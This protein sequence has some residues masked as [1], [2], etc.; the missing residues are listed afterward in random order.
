MS[1][2]PLAAGAHHR[3]RWRL[4]WSAACSSGDDDTSTG[5]GADEIADPGDCTP[6]DM[7]VSSEKIALLTD[8]ANE[9]NDSTPP[10]SARACQQVKASGAAMQL[11]DGWPEP[12]ERTATRRGRPPRR[13]DPRPAPDRE[14][15]PHGA[16]EP[17]CSRRS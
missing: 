4:R 17:F 8:L 9:F 10:I 12:G 13:R 15:E 2:A 11:T 5:A 1:T 16:A 6:V 3:R 7:A 14:G